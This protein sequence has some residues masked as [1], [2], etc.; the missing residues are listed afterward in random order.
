MSAEL[1]DVLTDSGLFDQVEVGTTDNPD[2]LVIALCRFHAHLDEGVVAERLEQLWNDR[3]RYPFWE[4][5]TMLVHVDQVELEGA[6]RY[7][8]AGHYMTLHVVAQKRA[9]KRAQEKV[10]VPMQRAATD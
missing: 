8:S 10:A 1:T 5:H 7:S 2:A 6:T 9:Q 4:A 3:L